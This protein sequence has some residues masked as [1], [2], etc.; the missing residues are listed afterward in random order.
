[1]IL[2]AD[3]VALLEEAVRAVDQL[4]VPIG[5]L[6]WHRALGDALRCALAD[7]RM[8]GFDRECWRRLPVET[9][10]MSSVRSVNYD[11]TRD[12]SRVDLRMVCAR[13]VARSE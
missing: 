8:V 1:M 13:W 12:R 3:P 11:V 6:T 10:V 7:V 5:K 2:D 9:G 4:V